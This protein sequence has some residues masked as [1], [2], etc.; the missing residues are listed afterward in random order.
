MFSIFSGG[1]E[2][3]P[4]GKGKGEGRPSSFLL[5]VIV[6]DYKVTYATM[7]QDVTL[8]NGQPVE[9]IEGMWSDFVASSSPNYKEGGS[10]CYVTLMRK[11]G[12]GMSSRTFKPNLLLVR[13]EVRG[14]LPNQDFRNSLYALM[15]S[16]VPSIN[17]LHAIYCFL[18]R[19]VV[20]AELNRLGAKLGPEA[21]PLAHQSFFS[22]HREFIYGDSFPAV[23]KVGH[24]H[25]G[26]G[27]MKI[28]DHHQMADFR[29]V[30]AVTGQYVA[31]EPFLYG[32][33]DL[34]IQYIRGSKVRVFQRESVSGDWK[35]NTGSSHMTEV[36]NDEVSPL[37]IAWAEHV[38]TIFGGLDICTVDA[39]HDSKTGKDV[40]MEV[41]GSSSGLSPFNVEQDMAAICSLVLDK[42][43]QIISM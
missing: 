14:A 20:Q 36:P 32:S 13:S 11:T 1:K 33:Y 30:L 22:S 3:P 7:F 27:K 4:E 28:E 35:T 9:V 23:V 43:N 6:P 38:S 39:L 42:M 25:G 26:Y 8:H 37:H 31:A 5:F 10:D 24:A 41:N 16:N 18:E 12:E 21:F 34:R 19:P 2:N 15:Y 40:I 29:S 17:S